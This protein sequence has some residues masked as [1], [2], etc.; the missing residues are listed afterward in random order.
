MNV[1]NNS[2]MRTL[3]REL[4]ADATRILDRLDTLKT[5]QLVLSGTGCHLSD[6]AGWA[7]DSWRGWVREASRGPSHLS[8]EQILEGV[9]ELDRKVT[10]RQQRLEKV[11][12]Q[13]L[14]ERALRHQEQQ[15]QQLKARQRQKAKRRAKTKTGRKQRRSQRR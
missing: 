9:R 12:T 6:K 15:R 14:Y 2:T 4:L 3:S 5:R 8:A 7:I 11:R 1:P 10:Q 13:A